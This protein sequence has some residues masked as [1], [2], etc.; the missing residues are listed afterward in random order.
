LGK[1]TTKTVEPGSF[2]PVND[3]VTSV[4]Q[5]LARC[6]P[7]TITLAGS[8]EPTL[9]SEIDAVIA[10]L[11][12]ISDTPVAL[13]TNGSLLWKKEV[14]NRV[15]GAYVILPTLTS[16]IPETF[17][18]IHRPH[19]ALDPMMIV[20]GLKRLR[21]E[22]QGQLFL[23]V[24]LLAGI[25]DNEKELEGLGECIKQIDPDKVQLNT[26][27]RPPTDGRAMP[28]DRKRLEEIQVQ[29]GDKAEIVAETPSVLTGVKTDIPVK[30]LLEMLRRRP[31]RPVDI[32]TALKLSMEDVEDMLKG[33]LIKGYV[34]QQEYSGEIYYLSDERD[35]PK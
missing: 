9:H 26:V 31:L 21:R 14:R 1:T 11:K 6:E 29:F 17:R 24:V 28:L 4:Q 19:P 22:F 27:V 30:E 16:T 7:D 18:R 33:L 34:L 3:V 20:D 8:G 23:E 10:S 5:R 13:L 2:V 32:S 35:V 25:N 15:L 12:Q